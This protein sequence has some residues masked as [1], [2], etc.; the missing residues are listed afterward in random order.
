MSQ[1]LP[2]VNKQFVLH[3]LQ[4]NF[5]ENIIAVIPIKGGETSLAY[6]FATDN[7]EYVLRLNISSSSFEKDKY[8]YEH[9]NSDKIP[10]PKVAGLGQISKELYYA[11]TERA[12]GDIL[13]NI[14]KQT[15]QNIL[16]QLIS[17]LE[18]IHTIDI[19]NKS[20]YGDWDK[21]GNAHYKSWREYILHIRNNDYY[22]WSRLII[23]G[24]YDK[25]VLKKAYNAIVKYVEFVS[26]ER[27]LLHADYGFN[28]V[29][30][31]G[32][33]ITG[34]IDWGVSKYGDFL[35]DVA[36]LDYWSDFGYSKVFKEYYQSIHKNID[37]YEERLLCYKIYIGLGAS[38]FFA[39]F[40]KQHSYE[41]TRDRLLKL[42]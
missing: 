30:S 31:D 12:T 24:K 1:Q 11:V 7:K 10:V 5:D 6:F 2:I 27:V 36:W 17:V 32:I 42:L 4:N 40:G 25:E 18:E 22:N 23:E 34:V 9:F 26:E 20:G 28:N 39:K 14:D 41:W 19:T 33:K 8:A 38:G 35:F 13:D 15:F 16:P 21:D 29:L 3:F 37:K